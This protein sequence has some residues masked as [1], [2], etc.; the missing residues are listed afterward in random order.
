MMYYMPND[1]PKFTINNKIQVTSSST[2]FL[3]TETS[4]SLNLCNLRFIN[5]KEL[6]V[7]RKTHVSGSM[8]TGVI[9]RKRFSL[10]GSL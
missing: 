3:I 9:E 8:G 4:M 6:D 2:F 10:F 1:I 7:L 5:S